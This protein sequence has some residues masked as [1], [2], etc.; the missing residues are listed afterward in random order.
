[1]TNEELIQLIHSLRKQCSFGVTSEGQIVEWFSELDESQPTQTEIDNAYEAFALEQ[2]KKEAVAELKRL[3]ELLLSN[4]SNEYHQYERETWHKQEREAKSFV[5][6]S[7]SHTPFL[8][9]LAS[10][11]GITTEDLVSKVLAKIDQYEN[12]VAYAIDFND[13]YEEQIK[14]SK[15]IDELQSILTSLQSEYNNG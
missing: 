1:M 9:K 12:L 2:T 6:D 5:E 15:S 14:N 4:V 3:F 11:K 7:N 13:R 10:K 8:D